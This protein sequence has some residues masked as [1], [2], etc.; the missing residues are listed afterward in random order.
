MQCWRPTDRGRPG[1]LGTLFSNYTG[2][3]NS[4]HYPLCLLGGEVSA[5]RTRQYVRLSTPPVVN[6]KETTRPPRTSVFRLA[7]AGNRYAISRGDVHQDVAHAEV[8]ILHQRL[9]EEIG[10]VVNRVDV[11]DAQ[12]HIFHTFSNE[13]MSTIDV[14]GERVQLGIVQNRNC[15]LIVHTHL[16]GLGGAVAELVQET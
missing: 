15:R 9:S 3:D 2:V 11:R 6:I 4:L 10:E 14:F 12:L 5:E 1:C 8:V 16:D 13:E 7:F